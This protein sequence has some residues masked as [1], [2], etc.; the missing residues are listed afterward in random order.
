MVDEKWGASE[1]RSQ[2]VAW[3][4]AS[5][6]TYIEGK[7]SPHCP[8]FFVIHEGEKCETSVSFEVYQKMF[9]GRKGGMCCPCGTRGEGTGL[10]I[11]RL[12]VWEQEGL[13][14]DGCLLNS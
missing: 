8:I 11:P 7:V 6:V 4:G 10:E 13:K 1:H 9:E 3:Q 2:G 12:L 14:P 5:F